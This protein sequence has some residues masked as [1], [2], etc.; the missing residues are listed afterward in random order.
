M[1]PGIF[2]GLSM[3]EYLALPAVSQGVLQTLLDK[4]PRAAWFDS[5]LNPNR[6]RGEDSDEMDAGTIAHA[7]LLE[8]STAGV[9]VID[10]LDHPAEKGGGIPVGWTNK[11]IRA[12]RDAARADGKV[13]VLKG[14]MAEINAMVDSARS[15]IE[16]LKTSEPEIWAA[17]Q[18]GGGESETTFVW[19]DNSILCRCRPDRISADRKLIIDLK[20]TA[21]SAEP[22]AWGRTQMVK[23]GRYTGAAFYHRG[24]A[25]LCNEMPA[26]VYLV[27]ETAPPYLC[28]L[29]GVDPHG[30]GL[31]AAKIALAMKEWRQCVLD[32]VWP[33]YPNRVAYPE[34]PPW[35][36]A[37]W[38]ER[39]GN[40]EQGIPY[41]VSKLFKKE[42]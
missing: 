1:N 29:V 4:C 25:T 35:E 37:R 40:D 22:D 39:L 2:P 24:V 34:I 5:Y 31:G 41:D 11:S 17:F 16:S 18:T 13:P 33:G 27:V 12:A 6:P 10:P 20:T 14:K 7:I 28:S 19:I 32:G 23:E 15:Y 38:A 30:M 26:Y 8:G 21:A 9:A 42:G 36:D 3:A